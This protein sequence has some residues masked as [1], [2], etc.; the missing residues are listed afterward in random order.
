MIKYPLSLCA[1]FLVQLCPE[2]NIALQRVQEQRE[3]QYGDNKNFCKK[4][5]R[6]GN[7]KLSDS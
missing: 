3:K 2:E 1:A 5:H 4:V 7:H 6:T